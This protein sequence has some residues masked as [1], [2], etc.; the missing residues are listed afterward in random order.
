MCSRNILGLG[1][2]KVVQVDHFLKNA[3]KRAILAHFVS[4]YK[5]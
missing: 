5:K 3:K 2:I 1:V 4:D